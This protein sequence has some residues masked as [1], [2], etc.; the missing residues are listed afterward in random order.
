MTQ[1]HSWDRQALAAA[2]ACLGADKMCCNGGVVCCHACSAIYSRQWRSNRRSDVDVAGA[3]ACVNDKWSRSLT[4]DTSWPILSNDASLSPTIPP[5]RSSH[6]I[7]WES[8]IT[9][10]TRAERPAG[11][12]LTR[13]KVETKGTRAGRRVRTSRNT[14]V[15]IYRWHWQIRRRQWRGHVHVRGS[16]RHTF[17]RHIQGPDG[18]A[19]ESR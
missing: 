13:L 8:T 7:A 11:P 1:H 6:R 5:H 4:R 12:A 3:I 17:R 10:Q 16:D 14:H 15:Q 2:H 19:L 9:C 18:T